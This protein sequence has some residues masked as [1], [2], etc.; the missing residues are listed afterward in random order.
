METE[1][2]FK[3]ITSGNWNLPDEVSLR[4]GPR[5]AAPGAHP[6]L[7]HILAPQ[8]SDEVPIEIRGLF[9]VARGAMVY[10]YYFY[11]LYTLAMEQLFRVGEAALLAKLHEIDPSGK[12]IGFSE[13]IGLLAEKGILDESTSKRMHAMRTLRNSASHPDRQSIFPPGCS[14]GAMERVAEDINA[15]CPF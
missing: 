8:L 6:H 3:A 15:L 4:F 10:A 7:S 2:G 11:P 13:A 9:E 12:R 14:I 5:G 1:L